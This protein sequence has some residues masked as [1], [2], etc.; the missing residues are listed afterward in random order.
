M[1]GV[2]PR[3]PRAPGVVGFAIE[4]APD[5]AQGAY[6]LAVYDALTE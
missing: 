1:T 3:D 2:R 5:E 4:N 6:W